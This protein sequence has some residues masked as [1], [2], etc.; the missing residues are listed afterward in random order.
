MVDTRDTRQPVRRLALEGKR[1]G[2]RFR[3]G[4]KHY[5]RQSGLCALALLLI[6]LAVDV[7]AHAALVVAIASSAFIV[8][9]MPHRRESAP[10][11]VVGGHL[12]AV[13]I[14]AAIALLEEIPAITALTEQSH[15]VVDLLAVLA[16]GLS[17]LVMV[18]TKT[19][20]PPAAG[21]ALG[22][23]VEGYAASS[24]LFVL[25]GAIILALAHR[26]LRPRLID[27]L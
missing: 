18:V 22:L 3:R 20:H 11:R 19:A 9:V 24:V 6:M 10:R 27:L 8:F 25:V 7:V 15:V 23:V 17:V 1:I 4:W 26:L 12:I 2:R 5:L 16:V 14:G 13:V 21:T